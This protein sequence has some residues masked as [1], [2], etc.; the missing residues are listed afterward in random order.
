MN[1]SA[2]ATRNPLLGG[3]LQQPQQPNYAGPLIDQSGNKAYPAFLS[4]AAAEAAMQPPEPGMVWNSRNGAWQYTSAGPLRGTPVGGKPFNPLLG[5]SLQPQPPDNRVG[6]GIKP[7]G[8]SDADW[9]GYLSAKTAAEERRREEG[10]M[11]NHMIRPGEGGYD[12]WKN[13]EVSL[14]A[15]KEK[16]GPG[17]TGLATD[18]DGVMT[19]VDKEGNVLPPLV[20]PMAPLRPASLPLNEMPLPPP[21]IVPEGYHI[22]RMR[23]WEGQLVKNG[24]NPMGNPLGAEKSLGETMIPSSALTPPPMAPPVA[25]AVAP[26]MM[27]P[28][29]MAP[30]AF[31]TKQSRPLGSEQQTAGPQQDDGQQYKELGKSALD[32]AYFSTINTTAP[33]QQSPNMGA[34]SLNLG[35]QGAN[36]YSG[37][38]MFNAGG[39][40]NNF[41]RAEGGRLSSEQAMEYRDMANKN[42]L[43]AMRVAQGVPN[44]MQNMPNPM[45]SQQAPQAPSGL[46]AMPMNTQAPIPVFQP[47]VGRGEEDM[48]VRQNVNEILTATL[49]DGDSLAAKALEVLTKNAGVDIT[50]AVETQYSLVDTQAAQP[51]MEMAMMEDADPVQF[52]AQY[53]GGIMG[54][55]AGGEFSG[56]VEGDGGGME[57]NV[58]MP[59][60]ERAMGQQVGT[61]DNPKQ[62]GTLAVS[63]SEYVIDSHTMAALGNGNADEGADVMDNV[64]KD[65][66]KDAYGNTRQ[67]NEINGLASLTSSINERT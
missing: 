10:P 32:E 48:D 54:L 67:P 41:G 31:N 9:Q 18:I 1:M 28:P 19:N 52:N 39:G 42:P 5:G 20:P 6:W 55:K 3:A 64:V 46:A 16:Y 14:A 60:I 27:A 36:I 21:Q 56:R 22:S 38:S 4:Q 40:M 49:P 26:P 23:G 2:K 47:T 53:G 13:N 24:F 43:D 62:V 44:P 11:G 57:D 65:I 33:G 8:A 15:N 34:Q 29:Y 7:E 58:Y 63:P 37:N 51:F 25:P 30:T 12:T 59:I 17:Y 61:L 66:R 35:M 50:E 45:A